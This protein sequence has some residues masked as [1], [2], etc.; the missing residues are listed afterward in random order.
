MAVQQTKGIRA[1]Y[2]ISE[3]EPESTFVLF[4]RKA[5]ILANVQ[6]WINTPL[7]HDPQDTFDEDRHHWV[8][9]TLINPVPEA[10]DLDGNF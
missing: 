2:P 5:K 3:I 8:F 6:G 7:T 1:D 10:K 4:N 9:I